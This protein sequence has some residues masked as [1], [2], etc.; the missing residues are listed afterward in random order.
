MLSPAALLQPLPIPHQVW[1]DISMDFVK[2]LL[3][4]DKEL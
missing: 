1:A 3:V 2:G 4:L